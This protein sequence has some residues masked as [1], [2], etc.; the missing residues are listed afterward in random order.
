MTGHTKD[1]ITK[2]AMTVPI[3]TVTGRAVNG[4]CANMSH[5]SADRVIFATNLFFVIFQYVGIIARFMQ[6]FLI[7]IGRPNS[8]VI[9]RYMRV[10]HFR[11]GLHGQAV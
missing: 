7:R 9:T 3:Y 2:P 8:T 10:I 4:P 5:F 6:L 1:I 11:Y